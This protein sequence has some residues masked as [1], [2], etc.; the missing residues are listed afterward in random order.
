MHAAA[1][2]DHDVAYE[3]MYVL[4]VKFDHKPAC[5]FYHGI[6]FMTSPMVSRKTPVIS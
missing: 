6:D 2:V 5:H 3:T 1:V 4:L